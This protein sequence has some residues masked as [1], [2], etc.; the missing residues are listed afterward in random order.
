MVVVV[1]D[2][3]DNPGV[4]GGGGDPLTT[5]LRPPDA[6]ILAARRDRFA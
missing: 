4:S 3:G 2:A 1:A 5:L 6:R